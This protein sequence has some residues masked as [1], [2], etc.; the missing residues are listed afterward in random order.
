[1]VSSVASEP[2]LVRLSIRFR[3]HKEA[4]IKGSFGVPY[5][6]HP[7]DTAVRRCLTRVFPYGIPGKF[8]DGRNGPFVRRIRF[9]RADGMVRRRLLLLAPGR[10]G[11]PSDR[12]GGDNARSRLPVLD[13]SQGTWYSTI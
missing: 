11:L 3:C 7:F 12:R 9:H 4:L 2:L 8:A 5:R 1:M 6:Q 10:C 13:P